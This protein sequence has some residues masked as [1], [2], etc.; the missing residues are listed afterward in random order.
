[1]SEHSQSSPPKTYFVIWATLL[2]FTYVTYK[3]AFIDLRPFNAAIALTIATIKATLVAL[4]FMHVWHAGEKLIKLVII[5]ALF[6]LFLLLGLT[7]TD[8]LTRLW[9]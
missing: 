8:Y 3:V 5:S 6:F 4:F 7:M 9:S 2:V 1:M